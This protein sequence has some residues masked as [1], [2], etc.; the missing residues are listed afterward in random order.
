[1]KTFSVFFVISLLRAIVCDHNYGVAPPLY[2][3]GHENYIIT[4]EKD[5][6][7]LPCRTNAKETKNI[8]YKDD[9]VVKENISHT[10]RIS[11][12]NR[13]NAG[14]YRCVALNAHGGLRSTLTKL[15][16]GCEF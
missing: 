4:P 14:N 7:I 12:T 9:I 1:M 13:K 11:P 5:S 10:F 16:I 3:S 6:V 15:E 8:W 2:F